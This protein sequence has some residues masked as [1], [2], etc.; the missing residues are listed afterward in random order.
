M[1]GVLYCY[2]MLRNR[3]H[4]IEASDQP[5]GGR[6]ASVNCC[7]EPALIRENMPRTQS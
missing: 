2:I 7:R 3:S 6:R 4:E 1:T 5:E